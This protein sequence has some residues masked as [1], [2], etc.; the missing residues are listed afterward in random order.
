MMHL[1][2]TGHAPYDSWLTLG[3][4]KGDSHRAMG[5]VGLPFDSWT[6]TSALSS[7]NGGIFFMNP[8]HG[9]ADRLVWRVLLISSTF[10]TWLLQLQLSN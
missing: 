10:S 3:I 8:A 2:K 1:D 5:M 7:N 9:P 6:E 4:T